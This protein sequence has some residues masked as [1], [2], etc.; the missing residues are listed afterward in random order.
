MTGIQ[1]IIEVRVQFE[2]VVQKDNRGDKLKSEETDYS[3][4]LVSVKTTL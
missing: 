4:R 1:V 2:L 3:L